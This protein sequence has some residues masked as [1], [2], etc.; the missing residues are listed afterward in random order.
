M[1]TLKA[2]RS[3][4]RSRED[5]KPQVAGDLLDSFDDTQ[6]EAPDF[7]INSLTLRME[8]QR[9]VQ[10]KYLPLGMD[11]ENLKKSFPITFELNM[12]L[13]LQNL[14]IEYTKN[15][16]SWKANP[17]HGI[18]TIYQENK[19]FECKDYNIDIE[20]ESKNHTFPFPRQNNILNN[21]F[22]DL[23]VLSVLDISTTKAG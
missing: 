9:I 11:L 14:L 22:P 18:V 2:W 17:T 5:N 10:L 4:L 15:Q 1:E 13:C 23:R 19:P 21:S 6:W 16:G 3:I 7:D 8:S 12:M 20:I